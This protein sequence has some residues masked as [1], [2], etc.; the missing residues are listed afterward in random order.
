[1][2]DGLKILNHFLRNLDKTL[3]IL[4]NRKGDSLRPSIELNFKKYCDDKNVPNLKKLNLNDF[5]NLL[6]VINLN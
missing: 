3:K 2:S 4:S 1:M 5:N 6:K